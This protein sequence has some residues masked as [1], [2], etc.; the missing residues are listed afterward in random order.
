ML[1]IVSKAQILSDRSERDPA[2]DSASSI[3]QDLLRSS[4][5]QLLVAPV[6]NMAPVQPGSSVY[7]AAPV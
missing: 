7:A 2:D 5:Y 3:R 1:N 6:E 4:F